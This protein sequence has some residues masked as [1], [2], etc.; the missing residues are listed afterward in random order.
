MEAA[1]DKLTASRKKVAPKMK[2]SL[3]DRLKKL[4][5]SHAAIELQINA[6][7]TYEESMAKTM[8]LSYS[9]PI[10][11]NHSAMYLKLPQEVRWPA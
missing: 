2:K 3:E 5:V 6:L 9:Q 7:D 1:A 4:G 10:K 11:I 8:P